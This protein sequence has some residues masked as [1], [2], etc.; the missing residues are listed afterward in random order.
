MLAADSRTQFKSGRQPLARIIHDSVVALLPTTEF[1]LIF[2]A[3]SC[4]SR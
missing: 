4:G 2:A 3:M 1:R